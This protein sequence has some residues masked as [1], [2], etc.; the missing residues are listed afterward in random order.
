MCK[1]CRGNIEK[2]L[3]P[4]KIKQGFQDIGLEK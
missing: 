1:K 3:K 4:K 2:A